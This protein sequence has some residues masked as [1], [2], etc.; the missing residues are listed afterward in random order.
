MRFLL[1]VGHKEF[2]PSFHHRPGQGHSVPFRSEDAYK[3]VSPH[4]RLQ[5]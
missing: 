1:N 4:R 2:L 5:G 3:V